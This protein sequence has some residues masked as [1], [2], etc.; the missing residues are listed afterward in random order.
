MKLRLLPTLCAA[1]F[2]APAFALTAT[3][4][5]LVPGS[6]IASGYTENGIQFT[7]P[8]SLNVVSGYQAGNLF[9]GG[10]SYSGNAL[11]VTNQGWVGIGVSGSLLDSVSFR[12]GFDWD[13]YSI[14]YGLMD[15]AVEWQAR[16]NGTVVATGGVAFDR[17]HRSHGGGWLTASGDS[18]FD[19]LWVRST[20]VGYQAVPGSNGW[21]YDR[22]DVIGYGNANHVAF[23]D[24]NVTLAAQRALVAVPD[25]TSSLVLLGIAATGTLIALRSRRLHGAL[26]AADESDRVE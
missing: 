13:F 18:P 2:A 25:D 21:I 7:S 8:T 15:V 23:D 17:D 26:E 10:Y 1:A 9:G 12:Y 16:L 5:A 20:A 11:A 6:S 19:E 3:F 22:G 4:D 14:E 24:V